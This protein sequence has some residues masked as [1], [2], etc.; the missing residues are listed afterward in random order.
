MRTWPT[1]TAKENLSA[2]ALAS[3]TGTWQLHTGAG[4]QLV[5]G[6]FPPFAYNASKGGGQ[7]VQG[8]TDGHGLVSLLVPCAGLTIP[9]LDGRTARLYG[10]PLP[11]GIS[12][13]ITPDVLEGCLNP[14]TGELELTFR[15][16][17][18]FTVGPAKAPLY[19][20]SD[21]VVETAL[22]SGNVQGE[23]HRGRG[24]ALNGQ[25]RGRLVGVAT[26]APCQDGWLNAFLGLPDE[27]L[28]VMDVQLIGPWS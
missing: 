8:P 6:R 5:I 16:R 4:C 7:V 17:F 12:V 19:Q 22:T 3:D 26:I 25:G 23:R 21:L 1:G 9:P 14:G 11:P 13:Q 28:A 27:A 18:R 10:L 24:Q 20:A 2:S 15:S